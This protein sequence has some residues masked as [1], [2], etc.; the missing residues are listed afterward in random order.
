MQFEAR[1]ETKE[2]STESVRGLKTSD[3][4]S[5][6]N[7]VHATCLKF[8]FSPKIA[9]K[10]LIHAIIRQEQPRSQPTYNMKHK[11]ESVSSH[12]YRAESF[13]LLVFCRAVLTA[14]VQRKG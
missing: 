10:K 6:L 3:M 11:H 9:I 2:I 8:Y 12:W 4:N 7:T 1:A 14:I 5:P 13:L